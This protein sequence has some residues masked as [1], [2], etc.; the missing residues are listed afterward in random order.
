[1]LNIQHDGNEPLGGQ[2]V[3]EKH[4]YLTLLY[5]PIMGFAMYMTILL[6]VITQKHKMFT[7]KI[8]YGNRHR[9]AGAFHLMI[10]LLYTLQLHCEAFWPVQAVSVRPP[11]LHF[12]D[13]FTLDI[14][15]GLSGIML[16]HTAIYDFRSAHQDSR[17]NNV[18]SGALDS[19]STITV[20]EM[21]EHSF[22]QIINLV[23]IIF[24]HTVS[25]KSLLSRMVALFAVTAPWIFRQ[26]FPINS[27]S[28]NYNSKKPGTDPTSLIDILYRIKKYQ[29]LFYKHFMLH[30]LN[31]SVAVWGL[32]VAQKLFFRTYW[33]GLN[34][35]YVMEFFLQTMVKR[36]YVSQNCMLQMNVFLMICST[37]AALHLVN[38][39][40]APV[41]LLSL[42][43]NFVNRKREMMNVAIISLF[44]H[45]LIATGF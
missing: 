39:I 34:A 21:L 14:T 44:A 16:T 10:L 33:L 28:A 24:L 31:V 3:Q 25:D 11:I 45:L 2:G 6:S 42:W 30:G 9:V 29:Y 15:L 22:Y 7:G 17:I 27:F 38:V 32:S 41:S 5:A 13:Y 1:M 37:I 35:A 26:S 40:S 18:A 19:A 20:G 43:L 36:R 4:E 12:I 8:N 23:Q